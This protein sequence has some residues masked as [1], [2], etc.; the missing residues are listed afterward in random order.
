MQRYLISSLVQA[1]LVLVG[2]LVLTFFMVR[3]TGDPARVMLAREASPKQVEEFRHKMGF[4]RPLLVQFIDYF[5]HVLVGDFG[6]SLNY[7]LPAVPLILERLPAT[8]QLASVAIVMA[9]VVA[10]P[11]GLIGGS[12]PGSPIDIISR[13]VGL[14]G[15]AVP[16]FWLALI[17]IIV[18][19]VRLHW[20]PTSGRDTPQSVLMPAFVLCL[21][22]MGRLVRLTRSS[23][24]EIMGDD[25]IRTARS[26]GLPPR[27]IYFRHA[28]KNAAI[29]LVSVI[30]VQFGYM[31][32][33][34]VIIESVF[35]WPGLGRMAIEAISIRDFPLVQ[36]IAIFSSLVVVGL[37]L[38]TDIGYALVDPRIRYE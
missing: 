22:T 7:R 34:S 10:V 1:V 15:Q 4:D 18:F 8:V 36:A 5:G 25:Y 33:G 24:L 38:L 17:M 14:F 27:V 16:A 26:K 31:L 13:G 6:K 19:A 35:A 20:L 21:P 23:I 29:G 3:L 32:G 30:G 9:V 2:V 11:L 28:L 37:N 12:R